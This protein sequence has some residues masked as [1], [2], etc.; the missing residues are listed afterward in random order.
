MRIAAIKGWR[1]VTITSTVYREV[2]EALPSAAS[3]AAEAV[4]VARAMSPMAP[5]PLLVAQV[6]DALHFE[7]T[8]TAPRAVVVEPRIPQDALQTTL[9]ISVAKLSLLSQEAISPFHLNRKIKN[10]LR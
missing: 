1:N 4:E 5:L 8:G 6:S 3:P 2:G 10:H 7:R 9:D